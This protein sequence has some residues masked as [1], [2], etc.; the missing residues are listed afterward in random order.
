MA[1][2]AVRRTTRFRSGPDLIRTAGV[3]VLV[4]G[5][6]AAGGPAS[7]GGTAATAA[8][9]ATLSWPVAGQ[10]ISD[11]HGQTAE[12]AISASNVSRLAP[13]WNFT[14]DGDVSATPTVA[15]GDVYFPDWGGE[16]WALTTSGSVVWSASVAGYTGLTGD[17]SRV[18]PAVDGNEL[19]IG[20]HLESGTTGPGA[21]V[22][23]VNR[24]TGALLW[25]TL[26]DSNPASQIT[27]SPV[28]YN[29]VVY[30]GI[31][32]REEDLAGQPGYQCCTFRG[33]VVA[34]DATTGAILWKT[35]DVPSN[36]GGS[37]SNIPG[38]YAGGAVWGSSPVVDPATGMLY[39]G[40]GNNYTVPDGVC[41]KPGQKSCTKPPAS[42]HF[43]SILGLSLSTGAIDWG[44][45]TEEGDTHSGAC[46]TI[47]GPDWDFGSMPNLLTT[48]NPATG[49]VEHLVGAGQKSG[50]YWALNPATGK[51][52]WKTKIGPGGSGGGIE[53][54][55]ATGASRVYCAE[56]DTG[57]K[58]YKL[59]GSG[60]QAGQTATGGSWA[61]LDA[62]TGE[63]LWQTP[64]PQKARD[65]GFVSTANGVLYANSNATKGTNM[66]ALDASTGAILW[67]FASGGSVR[68]GAAIVGKQIYWGTGYRTGNDDQ[69]YAF[70][71]PA[72]ARRA[73]GG[74]PAGG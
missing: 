63:M 65:S 60:P 57:H 18:S 41:D 68:S 19:I 55:C 61:A 21:S 37:D 7:A 54:G 12:K 53:W 44:F 27:G 6:L 66:Y 48:T 62:A 13:A 72:A 20:D 74:P 4:A 26:V 30:V 1:G 8:P 10:N 64:D 50:Y 5:L 11:T 52:A 16:L 2:L 23:A 67:S 70:A 29:G 28:V 35:Y 47:C 9:A 51:L 58:A 3:A 31:S 59:G 22:L 71:L 43:D 36:N 25:S 42:D 17:F 46:T 73:Q 24:T 39:V 14:T 34:L 69:F 33:A 40:T 49:K 38:Y 56:S 32:S 15:D 45:R